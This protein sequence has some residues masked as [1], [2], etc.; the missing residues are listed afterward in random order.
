MLLNCTITKVLKQKAQPFQNV[1]QNEWTTYKLMHHKHTTIEKVVIL[2]LPPFL[3]LC[4]CLPLLHTQ[5]RFSV[6]IVA[7]SRVAFVPYG[8]EKCPSSHS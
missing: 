2:F 8:L 3:S 7:L 1:F 4:L 5:L 6:F